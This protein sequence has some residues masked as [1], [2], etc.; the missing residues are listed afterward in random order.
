MISQSESSKIPES[1]LQNA[2]ALSRVCTIPPAKSA[3]LATSGVTIVFFFRIFT[4]FSG[5]SCR[6]GSPR[7]LDFDASWLSL[8]VCWMIK[9][10]VILHIPFCI[11]VSC[12]NHTPP[13][14]TTI[15]YSIPE[16]PSARAWSP[17]PARWYQGQVQTSFE[18]G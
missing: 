18:D 1:I 16:D 6:S 13:R 11:S 12:V 3:T 14:L 7:K 4:G 10:Q 15:G 17:Q 8:L 5:C 9:R 2:I